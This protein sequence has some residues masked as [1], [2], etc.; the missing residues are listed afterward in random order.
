LTEVRE[1]AVFDPAWVDEAATDEAAAEQIANDTQ[2][3][4]VAGVVGAPC[5][6]YEGEP[7][8]GQDRLD[9]LAWRLG[10]AAA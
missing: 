4:I 3:A 1:A 8:W 5:Y 10:Q 7:F 2:A 6:V 9:L